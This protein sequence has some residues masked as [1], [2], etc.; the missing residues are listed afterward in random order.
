MEKGNAMSEVREG[1]KRGGR[2]GEEDINRSFTVLHNNNLQL[3][4]LRDMSWLTGRGKD[5]VTLFLSLSQNYDNQNNHTLVLEWDQY[6]LNG[7]SY[8]L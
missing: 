4:L 3:S 7:H 8:A 6:R 5:L 2:E 1:G